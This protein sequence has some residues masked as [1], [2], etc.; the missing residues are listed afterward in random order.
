MLVKGTTMTKHVLIVTALAAALTVVPG[1]LYPSE[2][3]LQMGGFFTAAFIVTV[4]VHLGV[5]FGKIFMGTM[6]I[7]V[8][9]IAIFARYNKP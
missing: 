4:L 3:L 7:L 8:P 9:L 6:F 1:F 5:S 2:S